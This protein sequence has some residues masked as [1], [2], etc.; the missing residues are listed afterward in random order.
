MTHLN[1]KGG[2]MAWPHVWKLKIKLAPSTVSAITRQWV[3]LYSAPLTI[4]C[5]IMNT[6]EVE[7]ASWNL[8][9]KA[10]RWKISKVVAPSL[11]V[12][13]LSDRVLYKDTE[14]IALPIPD[15]VSTETERGWQDGL[16]WFHAPTV[17]GKRRHYLQLT[18]Q[19]SIILNSFWKYTHAESG[20]LVWVL[21]HFHPLPLPP[22][23]R[24][25][26]Q[27]LCRLW[28]HLLWL[29]CACVIPIHCWLR[30]LKEAV[31]KRLPNDI[32]CLMLPTQS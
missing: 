28:L 17:P 19:L 32:M 10:G 2:C 3:D 22:D 6:A 23:P 20:L 25:V 27:Q 14:I 24:M 31:Q 15:L 4:C 29:Y 8:L 18:G 7:A 12:S 16:V 9:I 1:S 26:R 21:Y 11:S 5:F 13:Y 30:T